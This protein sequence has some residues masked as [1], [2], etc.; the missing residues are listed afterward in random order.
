MELLIDV[1]SMRDLTFSQSNTLK[2]GEIAQNQ[3]CYVSLSES[4]SPNYKPFVYIN[5][6]K[7]QRV[8]Y[9]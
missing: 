8:K 4:P 5:M 9:I 1:G 2:I 6:K 3:D 7:P